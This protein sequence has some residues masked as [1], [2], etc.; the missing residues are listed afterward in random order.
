MRIPVS[1][2]MARFARLA[3]DV[4]AVIPS[5]TSDTTI[6][7]G[8]D[9]KFMKAALFRFPGPFQQNPQQSRMTFERLRHADFHARMGCR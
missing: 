1:F 3:I 5:P 8:L 4:S 9:E 2:K 7:M 6:F